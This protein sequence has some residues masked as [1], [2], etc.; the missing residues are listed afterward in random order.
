MHMPSIVGLVQGIRDVRPRQR[1]IGHLAAQE[2]GGLALPAELLV[3]AG[4]DAGDDLICEVGPAGLHLTTDAL[5]KVYVEVT[6]AC[7]L[8][9]GLRHLHPQCSDGSLF[10]SCSECLWAQGIVLGP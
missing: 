2:A 1:F 6:S 4:L 8:W 9:R 3:Q 5:R 10:P 7:R